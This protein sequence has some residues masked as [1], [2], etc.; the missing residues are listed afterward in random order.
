MLCLN[1]HRNGSLHM[2]STGVC[3]IF[4]RSIKWLHHVIRM[5]FATVAIKPKHLYTCWNITNTW[6]IHYSQ[7]HLKTVLQNWDE[8]TEHQNSWW[9]QHIHKQCIT[10]QSLSFLLSFDWMSW[11]QTSDQYLIFVHSVD[12]LWTYSWL[13]SLEF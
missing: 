10:W 4:S 8:Y 1:W 11:F 9:C 6:F 12:Q 5:Q 2:T 7:V 3:T 13:L